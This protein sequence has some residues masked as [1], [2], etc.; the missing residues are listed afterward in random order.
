MNELQK[1]IQ[2][3][4][5][6]IG[7]GIA[8]LSFAIRVA[9]YGKVIIITKKNNSDSNTNYAQG[10]IA[11]VISSDDEVSLHI[12]DTAKAGAGLCVPEAIHYLAQQG[13]RQIHQLMNWGAEFDTDNNGTLELGREG[14][15]TKHR[16]VHKKDYTGRE[17]ERALLAK[18]K[19]LPNITF[20]ENHFAIDL[21]TNEV[22]TKKSRKFQEKESDRECY[23]AYVLDIESNQVVVFQAK[24]TM[25]STGGAARVYQHSTNPPIATGDGV[26]MAFRAGAQIGNMEFFQFHPTTIYHPEGDSFLISEALRGYGAILKNKK[27]ESFM[28]KYHPLKCLAPRDIVARA[29]DNEMKQSGDPCVFLDITHKDSEATKHEFPQIYA[30]CLELGIDMT[31]ELIPVVPA[32]HYMC[33]GVKVDLKSR[34]NIRRLYA[35]GE[36]AFTG[37]H[38]ANRLA[39]N[40]LLEAVVFSESAA[41]DAG[42]LLHSLASH[43]DP[44]IPRWKRQKEIGYE[45]RI[46]VEHNRKEVAS[47]MWN[48]VGIVRSNERLQRAQTRLKILKKEVQESFSKRRLYP[49][50]LELRNYVT[51]ASLIIRSAIFRKESRGLHYTIDYPESS[52]RW[53]GSTIIERKKEPYLEPLE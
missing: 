20:F 32:A 4:F 24:V 27:G 6:V 13:S 39:S 18:A 28:E 42:E 21:I 25:L 47:I 16:I 36:T 52:E 2:S 15:H 45:E 35:C 9:A 12:E 46:L 51:T 37:V 22:I 34:T 48:Y 49:N 26:A 29:I 17:V 30:R 50:L 19:S 31:K 8:G 5:L 1:S 53:L 41:L 3:D 44:A 11:S 43:S 23:G 33:G 40:S 10:G 14:G 38:G 7:T